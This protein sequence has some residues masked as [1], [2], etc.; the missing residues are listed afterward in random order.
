TYDPAAEPLRGR[1]LRYLMVDELRRRPS[2]T[3]AELVAVIDGY[4]FTLTGRPSKVVSD[5]LRWE[6]RAGRVERL[7]RGLYRYRPTRRST[8][9]RVVIFA[10]LCRR[11][12]YAAQTGARL[13]RVPDEKRT[14]YRRLHDQN[15]PPWGHLGWLWTT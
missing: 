7:A 4:G 9:R 11:W 14:P 1:G 15:R 5:T 13:P 10:R 6:I 3:V 8:M 2:M 12:M